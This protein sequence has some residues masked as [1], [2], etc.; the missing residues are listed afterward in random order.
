MPLVYVNENYLVFDLV[1]DLV[2]WSNF[3][4]EGANPKHI[5][6]QYCGRDTQRGDAL[7]S[8]PTSDVNPL[9]VRIDPNLCKL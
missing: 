5:K 2:T 7:L 9:I 4:F 8:M 3:S 1:N 6:V